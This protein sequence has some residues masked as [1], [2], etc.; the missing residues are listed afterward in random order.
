VKQEVL[1]ARAL[2]LN[3]TEFESCLA[4]EKYRERVVN[5]VALA[6]SLEITGV[7]GFVIGLADSRNPGKVTG[8][9]SLRGAQPFTNF[10]KEIEAAIAANK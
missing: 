8:I 3:I 10:Q 2:D 5:N 7:P 9:S 1:Y 4:A 6:R